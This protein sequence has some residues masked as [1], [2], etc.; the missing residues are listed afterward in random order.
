MWPVYVHVY[1][2]VEYQVLVKG[3]VQLRDQLQVHGQVLVLVQVL[4]QVQTSDKRTLAKKALLCEKCASDALLFL[5]PLPPSSQ[6]L[7]AGVEAEARSTNLRNLPCLV[8]PLHADVD[9]V[10]S[11]VRRK[12]HS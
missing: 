3:Q 7:G 6:E 12:I 8:F 5:K 10:R 4:V 1:V 9:R 11:E 2:Q